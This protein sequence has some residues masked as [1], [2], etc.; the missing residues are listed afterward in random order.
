L[1]VVSYIGMTMAW[2]NNRK[3][4]DLPSTMVGCY[5]MYLGSFGIYIYNGH[6]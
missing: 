2:K 4:W 3:R 1:M 6:M 5:G